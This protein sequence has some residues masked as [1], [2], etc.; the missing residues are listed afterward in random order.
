MRAAAPG[1]P[2]LARRG[3]V[4]PAVVAPEQPACERCKEKRREQTEQHD[5]RQVTLLVQRLFLYVDDGLCLQLCGGLKGVSPQVPGDGLFRWGAC[6]YR[7]DNVNENRSRVTV[8]S[9]GAPAATE[10]TT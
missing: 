6:S 1:A 7:R 2:V 10:E 5:P 3:C 9:G 4:L 8:S